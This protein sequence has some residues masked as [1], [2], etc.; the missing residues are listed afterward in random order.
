MNNVLF[1]ILELLFGAFE[2]F[3]TTF[4]AL[5][6]FRFPPRL[7]WKET[8]FISS[9]TSIIA[10]VHYDFMDNHPVYNELFALALMFFM[11][12]KLLKVS[13]WHSMLVTVVGYLLL[14]IPA[15]LVLILLV[16]V[17]Q[18]GSFDQF[19][20]KTPYVIFLQTVIGFSLLLTGEV[21]YRKGIGYSLL[22]DKMLAEKSM[23]KTTMLLL[24]SMVCSLFVLEL[25]ITKQVVSFYL[26]GLLSV[27]VVLWLLYKQARKEML[28]HY[29]RFDIA[30]LSRQLNK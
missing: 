30:A 14:A 21:L 20:E 5:A 7:Y 27:N 29:K 6:V 18:V 28:E 4:A 3:G 19:F 10:L 8:L 26:L 23:R 2:V 24:A 25:A 13:Y 22:S 12:K 11:Y 15:T 17:L 1:L 9:I 16:D